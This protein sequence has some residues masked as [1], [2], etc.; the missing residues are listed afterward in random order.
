M[1]IPAVAAVPYFATSF[2]GTQAAVADLGMSAEL[3]DAQANPSSLSSCF[4]QILTQGFAAV[5]VDSIN[6]AIAIEGFKEVAAAGIPIV[7][8]NV[9]VPDGSPK[10]VTSFGADNVFAQTLASSAIIPDSNGTAAV[11]GVK[12]ID[13]DGTIFWW[14]QG[15]AAQYKKLCPDCTLTE[16]ETKTSDL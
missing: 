11:I 5:I 6:P 10:N 9:T 2:K 15:A 4:T 12:V 14:D 8:V 13:H 3:C 7:L 1:H 16:V